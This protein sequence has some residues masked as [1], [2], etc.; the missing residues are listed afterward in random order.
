MILA[1]GV[2]F[3]PTR[4]REPPAGFQDRCLKPLGHPSW[5]LRSSTYAVAGRERLGNIGGLGPQLDHSFIDRNNPDQKFG[6]L[7]NLRARLPANLIGTR[8]FGWGV[9][10]CGGGGHGPDG[11]ANAFGQD[12]NLCREKPTPSRPSAP[13]RFRSRTRRPRL[14]PSKISA[15]T[16]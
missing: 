14:Q 16:F 12:R 7:K 11:A 13:D 15:A 6:S 4:E 9:R 5:Q 3:E 1:E 8:A 10:I 2:G